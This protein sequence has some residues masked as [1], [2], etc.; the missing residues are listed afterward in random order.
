MKLLFSILVI[1]IDIQF[2]TA[3]TYDEW[4]R[5]GATQKR[6]LLQQIAALQVYSDYAEKEYS[7]VTK[8]LDA[9]QNIENGDFNLNNKYFSSLFIVNSNIKKIDRVANIIALQVF[10]TNQVRGIIKYC[11]KSGQLSPAEIKYLNKVFNNVLDECSKI[12]DELFGLVTN[13]ELQMR[14]DERVRRID[15]LYANMQER[16]VFVQSFANAA[17]GLS[18]QRLNDHFDIDME[19]KLSGLK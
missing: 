18:V 7:I 16:Q 15:V 2:T 12:L 11:V 1:F 17:K 14:D 8:G 9:I 13:G 19:N 4:F 5:Q 6:Y 3:Q 10:I